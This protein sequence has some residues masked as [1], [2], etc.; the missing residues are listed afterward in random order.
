MTAAQ[1]GGEMTFLGAARVV[2]TTPVTP[3]TSRLTNMSVR[4]TAG[5]GAQ[6][7]IVGFALA[8]TGGKELLVRGI[9]PTLSQFSV[10]NPLPSPTLTLYSG[11]TALSSN[12]RWALNP[13]ITPIFQKVGAFALSNANS[14]DTAIFT[15]RTSGGNEYTAHVSDAAGRTGVALMEVYDGD[16]LNTTSPR[17]KNLSARSRVGLNSEILIAG[18]TISGRSSMRVLIRGIGPGLTPLGVSGVISNPR[19]A[20]YNGNSLVTSND[21][22]GGNTQISS[23][24]A[25]VGAFALNQSSRDSALIATLNPGLY[26]AQLSGTGS[27]TGLGLIEVWEVP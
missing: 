13:E 23:A 7:L 6:T 2:G 21:D 20:L 8:G 19:L 26:T 17:L 15:T 11:N 18:F 4:S 3:T 25:S 14:L 12:T 22:W 5:P 1:L 10:P 24:A 16:P 9:G 27:E